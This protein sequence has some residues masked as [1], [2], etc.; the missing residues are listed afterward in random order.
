[1]FMKRLPIILLVLLP[2]KL[3]TLDL[4]AV[5]ESV[6]KTAAVRSAEYAL[7]AA[8]LKA[9]QLGYPGDISLSVQPG[10]TL[11]T[12]S[13]GPFADTVS[14]S[15]NVS[16]VVPLGLSDVK[17]ST[18]NQ[19]LTLIPQKERD[20]NYSLDQAYLDLVLLY[21]DVWINQESLKYQESARDAAQNTYNQKKTLFENGSI[22]L[23]ELNAAEELLIQAEE[24]L[25]KTNMNHKLSWIELATLTQRDW[26]QPEELT[27]AVDLQNGLP[28][29]MQ[30]IRWA[31][32]N[33]PDIL[34]QEEKVR[35]L[36]EE[37]TGLASYDLSAVIKSSVNI[38]N[39][40]IALSYNTDSMGLTGSYSFPLGTF[41]TVSSQQSGNW[42]M[43]FSASVGMDAGKSA[44]YTRS[45]LFNEFETETQKLVIIRENVSLQVRSKYQ[46][47]L[48]AQESVETAIR[49]FERAQAAYMLSS[50]KHELK[51]ITDTELAEALVQVDKSALQIEIARIAAMKAA[52]AAAH[53][54][55]YLDQYM[56]A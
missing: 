52:L 15:G 26:R 28:G 3:F 36:Q 2:V 27:K 30:L 4:Q 18:L 31:E 7:E 33:H 44:D 8:R 45:L 39:H 5:L 46:Q 37:L 17:E 43:S 53:A 25:S 10:A 32:T 12:P 29:S 1:M 16:V 13:D 47:Y 51:Q 49:N 41:G 6:P 56:E 54:A 42:T 48:I 50:T 9:D 22:S 34:A 55:A 20:Y 24:T 38:A 21:Q 40:N 23:L 14:L 35:L 19:T 11:Q